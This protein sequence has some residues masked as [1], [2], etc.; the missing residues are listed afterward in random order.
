MRPSTS[1]ASTD[2]ACNV[3]RRPLPTEDTTNISKESGRP[4]SGRPLSFYPITSKASKPAYNAILHRQKFIY[5]HQEGNL[6]RGVFFLFTQ[7]EG[8]LRKN[9]SQIP[10]WKSASA[11]IKVY[12][13]C[14]IFSVNLPSK[15]GPRLTGSGCFPAPNGEVL[16]FCGRPTKFPRPARCRA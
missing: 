8:N 16:F 6:P 4:S 10:P 2:L 1:W 5:I 3:L 14:S 7:Y 11:R 13:R 9:S 12:V 15:A